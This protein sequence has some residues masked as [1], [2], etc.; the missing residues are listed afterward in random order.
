[1]LFSLRDVPFKS[2]WVGGGGGT[3]GFLRAG[4][5]RILTY[6]IPLDYI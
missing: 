1:M 3:E 2:V 6:V 5:G 4:G